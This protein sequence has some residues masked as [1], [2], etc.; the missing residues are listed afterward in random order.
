[1]RVGP[2]AR[3]VFTERSDG[4]LGR[5]DPALEVEPP[6]EVEAARERLRAHAGVEQLLRGRQVHG[7]AMRRVDA[8]PASDDEEADGQA[9]ACADLAPTVHVA[10]CVPILL[11]GPAAVAA[12]HGG[13]R[14]LAAG[15]VAHGVAASPGATHA[16]IGPSIGPCC[17]QVGDEVRAAF[18]GLGAEVDDRVD[19]PL[20]AQ[21]LLE[22]AGVSHVERLDLCTACDRRF[23]SHRRD[24]ARTGRQAGAVWRT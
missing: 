19:L 17:F 16:V 22:R 6:G 24:G 11:G 13:W 20:V 9:T 23:F 21:R 15:I 4:S 5:T 7:A 8:A 18:A 1:M 2:G 12:L 14:G 3:G 10:D